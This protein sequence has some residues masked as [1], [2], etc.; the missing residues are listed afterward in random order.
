[1]TEFVVNP[2]TSRPLKVGSRLHKQLLASGE[3][4]SI[5]EEYSAVEATEDSDSSSSSSSSE[6]VVVVKKKPARRPSTKL[7][8]APSKVSRAPAKLVRTDSSIG[9]ESEV[10][11]LINI[12]LK[13]IL[14]P[15]AEA[16]SESD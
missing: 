6:E 12:E 11:R 15:E 8:R 9:E 4:F 10:R 16:E 2:K 14:N 1:M 13:K 7:C 5:P 3:L